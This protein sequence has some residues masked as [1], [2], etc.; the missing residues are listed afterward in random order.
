MKTFDNEALKRL[1]ARC[2]ELNEACDTE[3][4][5]FDIL[6]SEFELRDFLSDLSLLDDLDQDPYALIGALTVELDPIKD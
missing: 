1:E 6:V 2:H 3:A 4:Q 5:L